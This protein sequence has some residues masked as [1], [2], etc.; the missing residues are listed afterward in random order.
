MSFKNFDV[1]VQNLDDSTPEQFN[2]NVATVGSVVTLVPTSAKPIQFAYI[3]VNG[4]R[5]PDNPNAINDA[6]KYSIDGGTNF[7]TLM[8][9]ES[10]SLSGIFTDL[11]LDTNEDG[12]NYQVILWS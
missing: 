5:D 1:E 3:E 11:R 4:R 9:G 10:V 8:A 2:G 6:I 7:N 12:T